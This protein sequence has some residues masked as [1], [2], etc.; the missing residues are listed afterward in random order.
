MFLGLSVWS[1]WRAVGVG[2]LLEF[3]GV[4]IVLRRLRDH[5]KAHMQNSLGKAPT[6]EALRRLPSGHE[7]HSEDCGLYP[8]R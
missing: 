2:S 6:V 7:L 1:V 8:V 5:S 4:L 3:L